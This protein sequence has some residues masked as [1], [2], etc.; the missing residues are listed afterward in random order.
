MSTYPP[1]LLEFKFVQMNSAYF[2]WLPTDDP[3]PAGTVMNDL[4]LPAKYAKVMPD[5]FI[6]DSWADW[7]AVQAEPDLAPPPPPPMG[8]WTIEMSLPG[9]GVTTADPLSSIVALAHVD[10]IGDRTTPQT[11]QY[12]CTIELWTSDRDA[13]GALVQSIDAGLNDTNGQFYATFD[14]APADGVYHYTAIV[15]HERASSDGFEVAAV[16]P[17]APALPSKQ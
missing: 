15:G 5:K 6:P 1:E 13:T 16:A 10:E 7:A 2:S 12:G 3:P 11:G 8:H 17:L 4:T 14:P 9:D